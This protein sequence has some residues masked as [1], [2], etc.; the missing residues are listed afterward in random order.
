[1]SFTDPASP[2]PSRGATRRTVSVTLLVV[3]VVIATGVAIAGTAVAFELRPFLFPSPPSGLT[4]TDD[5]GRSITVPK[6]PSRTVVLGPN[7]MDTMFRLGLRSHVVGV[8]CANASYGGILGDYTSNQTAEWGLSS[9][10]CVT[11]YPSLSIE[12]LLNRSPQL[13]IASN[14]VGISSLEGVTTTYGIPVLIVDP[15]TLG[16]VVYDVQLLAKVFGVGQVAS[17]L[18]AELQQSLAGAQEFLM[19]LTQNGSPLRTVLMTYY[20]TPA[21]AP[22]AGYF[23]FGSGS[24]GQSL[25]ELSGGVNIAANSTEASPELSGS[26]VLAADPQFILYGIGFGVGLPQY[27]QGPDWSLLPAVQHGNVSGVG[28]TLMTEVDPSMVLSLHLF[29]HLFY[30]DLV[31]P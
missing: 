3:A 19:N 15:S 7:V 1:M 2:V 20:A 17:Q 18:V 31:G 30:P 12:D 6:D 28:V 10:L 5:L 13:V 23:T 29:R 27:Q 11:A 14:V 8:D 16:G 21:G 22:S 24:F 25:I 26:Q 9:S 4:V